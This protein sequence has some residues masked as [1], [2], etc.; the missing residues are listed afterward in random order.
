MK[1]GKGGQGPQ[2]SWI[3]QG[4]AK[5][6][7]CGFIPPGVD[8]PPPPAPLTFSPD[9]LPPYCSTYTP[10]LLSKWQLPPLYTQAAG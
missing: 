2:H 6:C 3:G 1:S 10:D 4:K 9:L 5:H 8:V 7:L